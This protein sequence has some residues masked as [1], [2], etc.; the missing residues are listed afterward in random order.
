MCLLLNG[1]VRLSLE[2]SDGK[3]MNILEIVIWFVRNLFLFNL[4]FC[5]GKIDFY[6]VFFKCYIKVM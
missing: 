2:N 1:R 4:D 3:K 5:R 6:N